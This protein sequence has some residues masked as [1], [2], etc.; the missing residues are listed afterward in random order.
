MT[1]TPSAEALRMREYRARLKQRHAHLVDAA[2]H[3]LQAVPDPQPVVG[4][5]EQAVRAELDL[6]PGAAQSCPALA[7]VA[8]SLAKM[9]DV[10]GCATSGVA[11]QL[12]ATLADLRVFS[13]GA[14]S[15]MRMASLRATLKDGTA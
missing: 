14:R 10:P 6:L 15:N 5:V 1:S 11:S 13:A 8:I 3:R 2:T 4:D 9:L 7:A 12:R